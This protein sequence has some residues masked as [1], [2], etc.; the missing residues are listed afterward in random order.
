MKIV[1]D[2]FKGIMPKMANDKI[3]IDNNKR[4]VNN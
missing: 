3:P 4:L 2:K 1:L